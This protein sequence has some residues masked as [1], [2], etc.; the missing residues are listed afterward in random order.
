MTEQE[1]E[2][3]V[4]E[5][6]IDK[7]FRIEWELYYKTPWSIKQ[8]LL[9]VMTDS[10]IAEI[11]WDKRREW[12]FIES[13]KKTRIKWERWDRRKLIEF[14]FLNKQEE[15]NKL[16]KSLQY[17][18]K[19]RTTQWWSWIDLEKA[20]ES[21]SIVEVIEVVAGIKIKNVNKLIRCPLHEDSTASFKIY[22]HTNT[23][24]CQWCHKGGKSIDFIKHFYNC[25][26]RE[27]IQKFLTFYCK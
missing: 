13:E 23:F 11:I 14:I 4:Q 9:S 3:D 25:T 7:W 6:Y 8:S 18:L 5:E 27:A 10:E 1:Y 17:V 21:I 24:Y 12:G 20:K 16:I 22:K 15:I 26:T 2:L 19:S